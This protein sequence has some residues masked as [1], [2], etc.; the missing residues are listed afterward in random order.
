MLKE[1]NYLLK[2]NIS[3]LFFFYFKGTQDVC[4]DRE[5][6]A[7]THENYC[8]ERS[9]YSHRALGAGAPAGHSTEVK[10]SQLVRRQERGKTWARAFIMVTMGK[11]QWLS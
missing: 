2:I 9:P 3:M 10:A 8:C 11:T 6:K 4:E 5:G 7:C 1:D